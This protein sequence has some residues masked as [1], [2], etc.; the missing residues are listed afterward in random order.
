[1]DGDE[2][3]FGVAVELHG[4]RSSVAIVAPAGELD[5]VTAPGLRVELITQIECR[6]HVILDLS[7]LSY[8]GSAGLKVIVEAH[9]AAQE[10]GGILRISGAGRR[11]VARSLSITGLDTLLVISGEPAV[12]L[13]AALTAEPAAGD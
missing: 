13:A 7:G 8:L 3:A 12:G 9:H 5:T 1:M 10:R 6:S 2:T 11:I 4:P